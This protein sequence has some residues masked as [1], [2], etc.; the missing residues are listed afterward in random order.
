[1]DNGYSLA[2]VAT[3]MG[4]R[5]GLGGMGGIGLLII[6]FLFLMRGGFGF[7]GGSG[8]YVTPSDLSSALSAQTSAMNQQSLLLSSAN[9]NYETARLIDNLGTTIMAQNNT[10][11]VN[12]IQGFNVVNQNLTAGFNSVNQN[13]CDLGY[14]LDKCCCEI[15][16]QMLQNRLDDA[17]AVIVSQNGALSN[18]QQTQTILGAMGRWVGYPP[19]AATA[20]AG[21]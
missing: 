11:L 2:D 7:G 8:D 3:V 14:K 20:S 1:M 6:L 19:V 15:K 18:A 4:G 21:A 10:N 5:E 17:Q 9:N 16:T 12:A 13:I